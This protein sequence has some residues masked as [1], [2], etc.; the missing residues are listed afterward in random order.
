MVHNYHVDH[1]CMRQTIRFKLLHIKP[2]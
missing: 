1:T 2:I